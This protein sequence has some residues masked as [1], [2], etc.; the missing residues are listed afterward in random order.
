MSVT[1]QWSVSLNSCLFAQIDFLFKCVLCVYVVNSPLS[2]EQQ[3]NG[4]EDGKKELQLHKKQQKVTERK[5]RSS[6]LIL[7]VRCVRTDEG[8]ENNL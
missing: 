8:V 2:F 6:A 3:R 5:K 1:L 7:R 4:G